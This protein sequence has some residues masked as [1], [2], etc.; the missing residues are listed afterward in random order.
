[1]N[2]KI[3]LIIILFLYSC[4]SRNINI[5]K[6]DII[7][8]DISYSNK[9]FTLVFD[10]SLKKKKI[11]NKKIGNRSLIIFQRNLKKDTSVKITN[12]LNNKSILAKVGANSKYPIFY[13]S[14]ISK[15]I[16]DELELDI[17]Q[18]YVEIVAISSNSI[19]FSKKS[20]M[21]DEEK[22]VADKA[23]VEGININ[24]LSSNKKIKKIIKNEIKFNYII[25]IADFYYEKTAEMMQIRMKDELNL[26]YS[27]IIKLSKTNYRVYLGPFDNLKSLKNAFDDITPLNF[28]NIEIIKL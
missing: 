18:P 15:R 17:N 1:M 10:E 25:K 4:D 13:N 27:K 12:L 24:D 20:K 7:T 14:V 26:N 6:R 3:I 16:Y 2:F 8:P 9:G 5:S 21:Y 23:P 22:E 19:F 11:I 28:E